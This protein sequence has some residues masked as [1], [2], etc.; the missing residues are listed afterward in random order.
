MIAVLGCILI[1]VIVFLIVVLAGCCLRH[2]NKGRRHSHQILFHT[3]P[4]QIEVTPNH[5]QM[6]PLPFQLIQNIGNGKYGSVWKALYNDQTVAVKIFSPHHKLSWQNERDIHILDSTPHENI[7]HFILGD[8]RGTGYNAEYFII[9][10]YYPLGSLNYFL[11]H[12]S[13]SWEQAW[14]V[15]Y[16]VSNGLTHLHSSNYTS[17][18]FV[19]EKYSIAHRDI[20]SSNVLVKNESGQ[21]VLAD[22]G[23]A[24]ILDPTADDRKLAISGQVSE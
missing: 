20:K 23:L 16:S 18:G 17:K 7:L 15:M 8:N 13:L 1:I 19:S 21:C 3:R 12:S 6:S 11:R 24:F 2:S 14:N 10:Q 9:T 22:L 5:H 4:P